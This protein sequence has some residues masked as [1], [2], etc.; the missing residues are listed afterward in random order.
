[1]AAAGVEEVVV[2][3]VVVVAGSAAAAT[4]GDSQILAGMGAR[5]QGPP[6]LLE[7]GPQTRDGFFAELNLSVLGVVGP[8]GS[9]W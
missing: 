4:T 2:G 9:P 7:Q 8:A 3:V 5:P 6:R 1:M